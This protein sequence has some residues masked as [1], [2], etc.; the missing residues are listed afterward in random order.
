MKELAPSSQPTR[1]IFGSTTASFVTHL[2]GALTC[3]SCW[4]IFG[5]ALALVFGSSVM[6]LMSAMRP[7]APLAIVI[8]AFGLGYS[9]LKLVR[10][11]NHSGKL[12]YRLAAAFTLVSVAGW[13]VSAV[14]VA[15]TA[16]KG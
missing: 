2:I 15:I 5:P 3:A 7:F 14:F 10:E 11:R 9:I 13:S 1:A 12:P 16:I 6:S 4:A 8:S